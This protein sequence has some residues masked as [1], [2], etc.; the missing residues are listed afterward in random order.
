T[1][2][3][4]IGGLG[5]REFGWVYLLSKVGVPQGVALGLSLINFV[6]MVLVGLLGGLFY[7]LTLSLGRVQ[8]HQPSAALLRGD[9]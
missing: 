2:L 1:S 5:V 6:F 4:S 3:P 7:V 8:H 9:A